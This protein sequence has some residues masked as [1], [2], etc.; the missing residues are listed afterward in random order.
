MN[1]PGPVAAAHAGAPPTPPPV[2]DTPAANIDPAIRTRLQNSLQS[3]Q[4]WRTLKRIAIEAAIPEETA[5]SVLRS[6]PDVRFSVGRSGDTIVG[7]ISR[8]GS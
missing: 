1:H 6:D 4:P 8:V 7:L 5:A 2:A 3:A